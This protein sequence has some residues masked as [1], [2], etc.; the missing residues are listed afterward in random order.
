M[1]IKIANFRELFETISPILI[2][3]TTTS[4]TIGLSKRFLLFNL[5]KR[6]IKTIEDDPY[7]NFISLLKN[8]KV[9]G[10]FLYGSV[11]EFHRDRNKLYFKNFFLE[12]HLYE[13]VKADLEWLNGK[14]SHL[15]MTITKRGVIIYDNYKKDTFNVL[16]LTIHSGNW[17]PK[18][19][20]DKGVLSRKNRFREE[21]V[22]THK[23]YSKLVLERSGI[24]IDNKQS[25]F[26]CDFNRHSSRAIYK[27][28]SEKWLEHIWEEQPTE[29]EIRQIMESYDEFYFTLG[30]L[31][32]AYKFNI[33][34]DAHSMKDLPE[35]PEL[36]FGTRYV[37]KFYMPI[38]RSMQRK[39]IS[40]G[41]SSVGLNKPYGGGHIL[42]WL[43][44][45]FP[46]IFIFSMEVNKSLY[47][48]KKADKTIKSKMKKISEDITKIF[49]IEVEV[50]ETSE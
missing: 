21:D 49:D 27:D 33:I 4:I 42:K 38:V 1:K 48:T 43:S 23:L 20:E 29:A 26:A 44:N 35:R 40:L 19:L 5:M 9:L 39:L 41:Y 14:Y 50:D 2:R 22:D 7:L 15:K 36:S 10:R 17:V 30:R 25:R 37:P 12:R 45:K 11:H 6:V 18:N 3:P 16:L 13:L 28:N 24:W 47:M 8:Y 32:D 46:N 34:F 31:I